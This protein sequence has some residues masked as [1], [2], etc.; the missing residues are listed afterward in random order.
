[1]FFVEL[2]S[3]TNNKD[4]YDIN[5]SLQSKIKFEQSYARCEVAML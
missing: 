3:A 2:K 5:S 1:M 4:I